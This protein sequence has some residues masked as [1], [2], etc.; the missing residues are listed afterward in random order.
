MSIADLSDGVRARWTIGARK[1]RQMISSS[2]HY[3]HELVRLRSTTDLFEWT[4]HKFSTKFPLRKYPSVITLELTNEC[5]F[6]CPH[7]A[8]DALN[9]T[10]GLGFIK[11]DVFDKVLNE[12]AGKVNLVKIIG[13]GEPGDLTSS[14]VNEIWHSNRLNEVRE[15]HQK[16]DLSKLPF[17]KTCQFW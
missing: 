14:T 7:C 6:S 9:A 16:H 10:R 2:S 4:Y 12:I 5:N 1:I 13:L 17:C 8:R 11:L 3:L 15:C